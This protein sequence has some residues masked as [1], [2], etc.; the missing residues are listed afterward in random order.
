MSASDGRGG[1]ERG[2]E[3]IVIQGFH[4]RAGVASEGTRSCPVPSSR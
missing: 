2:M 4:L 3:K 1:K